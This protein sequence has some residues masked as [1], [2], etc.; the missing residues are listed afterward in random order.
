MGNLKPQGEVILKNHQVLNV[1]L[2]TIVFYAALCTVSALMGVVIYAGI[3]NPIQRVYLEESKK[4]VQAAE[5]QLLFSG[6]L[7][8]FFRSSAP[9]DFILAAKNS[10]QAVVYIR[11]LF[12]M[13]EEGLLSE[14][15]GTETGSGVILSSDGY[16][17]TNHHVVKDAE[18]VDVMLNDNREYKAKVVG[19]DPNTDLALL[20][21]EADNL[22]FLV[23]GNSDSLQVGEWVMAIGN[24]FRLQSTVTAG[25]V[26][27]KGR[28]INILENQGIESFI[29]TDAAVNPGN[30]GGA[31]VNTK[32]E[33]VGI[34]T[35]IMTMSGNYEGFSFAVPANLVKKVVND[36]R[37]YGFVQ[38]GWLG[39]EIENIDDMRARKLQIPEVAGVYIALVTRNGAAFDAGL[40]SGDVITRLNGMEIESLP[41]FMETIGTY[42]PGD[43][44]K[45]DYIRNGKKSSTTATLRNQLNS[46]DLVAVRKDKVLID[47]GFE[48]RDLD[49]FE[50]SRNKSH[51]IKV[52]TVYRN[53]AVDNARLE[54]GY[55]I[56]RANG[57]SVETVADILKIIERK[58]E[59][60]DLVGFY[61]NYPGEFPYNIELNK[62]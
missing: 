42:K 14:S 56:T 45:I 34:N 21:I 5:H 40:Q 19:N 54:P 39:V 35:A 38:R 62:K 51:G 6:N 3:I 1:N 32:G 30:S 2:K 36:I 29:Q 52:I 17:V 33:L 4:A 60:L 26:S 15:Y 47:I 41:R 44:V 50:K 59:T 20:K 28:N 55:I 48:L 23:F 31:L 49:S 46:T 13:K 61:E 53:S 9:T 18:E 22:S 58:G 11:S 57:V 43:K 10:Q 7:D 25:I 8:R 24:P 27:A 12:R 16:I 37:Q